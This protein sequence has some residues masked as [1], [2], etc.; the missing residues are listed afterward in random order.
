MKKDFDI[1][2]KC[3]L[4][5]GFSEEEL[6]ASLAC[7]NAREKKLEKGQ[8][9]LHAGDEAQFV[10]VVLEGEVQILREDFDGARSVVGHAEAGQLFAEAF[11]C[12]GIAEMPVSVMAVRPSRV[13]LVP[14]ERILTPCSQ[15]CGFHSRLITNLMHVM[16]QK[17][18][19][20]H[21][22]VEVMSQ[23]TTREK[24][25]RYLRTEA[26]RQ[27]SLSFTIPFDRQALAD[28]LGVERSALSAEIGKMQRDGVIESRR[29]WFRL[30]G[31]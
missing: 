2:Q 1:L 19:Y 7:L 3:V 27:R 25:L 26:R 9:A 20:L 22:K 14:V 17:N 31:E 11:S 12:A 4:F 5:Q 13:M 6:F 10:G 21:Q 8:C 15:A 30:K 16:A 18:L 23:R 24:L 28:Y 29:S